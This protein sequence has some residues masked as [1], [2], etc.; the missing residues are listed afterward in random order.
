MT[1]MSRERAVCPIDGVEFEYRGLLSYGTYGSDLDGR[2]ISL[3]ET[4][5][6]LYDCPACRFPVRIR[7]LS[8]AELAKARVVVA[9]AGH[10]AMLQGASYARLDFLLTEL[11]RATPESTV[12]HLLCACW[13]TSPEDARYEGYARRLAA[14]ADCWE[15]MSDRSE[16]DRAAFQCS[17][18]NIMRQAGLWTEAEARLDRIDLDTGELAGLTVRI[19][20]TRRLI[21]GRDRGRH[22]AEVPGRRPS[23]LWPPR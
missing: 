4:P 14:A 3:I 22:P 18:A 20:Q 10:D 2:P 17:L 21:V 16:E 6:H 11:G 19:E 15:E 23:M 7:D 12:N 9:S 5:L 1:V 8:E 13:E